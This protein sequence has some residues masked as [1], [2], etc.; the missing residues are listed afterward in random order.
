MVINSRGYGLHE[1]Q[2]TTKGKHYY[3]IYPHKHIDPKLGIE[4][5]APGSTL[6]QDEGK[7]VELPNPIIRILENINMMPHF[8]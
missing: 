4:E 2:I 1:I 3:K 6:P 7:E 5:P 8:S